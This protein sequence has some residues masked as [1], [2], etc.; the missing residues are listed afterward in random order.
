MKDLICNASS[1]CIIN[2][3]DVKNRK[4]RYYYAVF[5]SPDLNGWIFN[6]NAFNRTIKNSRTRPLLREHNSLELIGKNLE[7]GTDE[8]GAWAVSQI[9]NTARGQEAIALISEGMLNKFS[10]VGFVVQG[11]KVEN[12]Y[13]YVR[14][15]TLE[16]TSL[17]LNPANS[18]A[19]L[20]GIENAIKN[21]LLHKFYQNKPLEP[22]PQPVHLDP[23]KTDSTA[24][25]ESLLTFIKNY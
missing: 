21:G 18:H 10:F 6:K 14:E 17:V 8:K 7:L 2:D 25:A 23:E 22:E 15:A 9:A 11:E 3:V 4:I 1:Q 24:G 16:E 19:E 5:E 13:T 20:I 12:G